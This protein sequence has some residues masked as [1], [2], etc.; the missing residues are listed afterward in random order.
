MDLDSYDLDIWQKLWNESTF[1]LKSRFAKIDTVLYVLFWRK[2]QLG[3]LCQQKIRND[4]AVTILM[5]EVCVA[6]Q[7]YP[8]S[9]YTYRIN[10]SMY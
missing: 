6:K 3:Y 8:F 1:I 9:K 2:G 7:G 4:Y 10:A 5:T